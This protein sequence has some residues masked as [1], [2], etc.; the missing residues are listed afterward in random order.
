MPRAQ[1]ALNLEVQVN[2]PWF[3]G[4]ADCAIQRAVVQ[5]N[6][7]HGV[8]FNT[9]HLQL[10]WSR[11][12]LPWDPLFCHKKSLC[13]WWVSWKGFWKESQGQPVSAQYPQCV[14]LVQRT[15]FTLEAC[16]PNWS[17]C[18]VPTPALVSVTLPGSHKTEVSHL[19]KIDCVT[20]SWRIGVKEGPARWL[21]SSEI[22]LCKPE[23]SSWNSLRKESR[24][25]RPPHTHWEMYTDT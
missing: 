20:L 22:W 11:Q 14:L 5:M 8:H 15:R 1:A 10:G 4:G 25:F 13:S 24:V 19:A 17:F 9:P 2:L 12:D 18:P 16:T 6:R 3:H 23:F 7:T 21:S